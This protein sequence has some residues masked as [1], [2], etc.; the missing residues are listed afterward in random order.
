MTILYRLVQE[1]DP[2]RAE[3]YY[4]TQMIDQDSDAPW[5]IVFGSLAY[6]KVT[7]EARYESICANGHQVK[8]EVLVQER[9]A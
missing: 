5:S 7:A 8:R 6:D 9:A 1:H 3:T 2:V 4:F